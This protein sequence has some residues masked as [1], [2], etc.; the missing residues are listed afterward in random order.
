MRGEG[1]FVSTP[2][3]ISPRTG[4]VIGVSQPRNGTSTLPGRRVVTNA[5]KPKFH[6][7]KVVHFG[8]KAARCLFNCT[9][10]RRNNPSGIF[11]LP[12]YPQ[13][14]YHSAH[15][16]LYKKTSLAMRSTASFSTPPGPKDGVPA[17]PLNWATQVFCGG[18]DE[19]FVP[20]L[21]TPSSFFS[22]KHR[23]SPIRARPLGS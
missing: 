6:I 16:C 8:R 20:V 13:T 19:D 1:A 10:K 18:A 21:S 3:P 17:V 5:Q 4:E 11:P 12:S 2:F 23:K 14:R 15:R 22:A 7:Y 9:A